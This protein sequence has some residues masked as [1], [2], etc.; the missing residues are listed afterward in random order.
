MIK[1]EQNTTL[2]TS[3]EQKISGKNSEFSKALAKVE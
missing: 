3:I 1:I 2:L